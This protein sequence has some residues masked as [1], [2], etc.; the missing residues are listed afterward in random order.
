V[1]LLR[2]AQV[3]AADSDQHVLTLDEAL[4]LAR[5]N[6]PQL[7]AARAQTEV[8]TA[9]VAEAKA[10]L[11][12]Q[13]NGSCFYQRSRANSPSASMAH[14]HRHRDRHCN[15]NVNVVHACVERVLGSVLQR[16]ALLPASS[17]TTSGR[18]QESG[19]REGDTSVAGR[20]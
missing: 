14:S 12:P 18:R 20:K 11:L 2:A 16:E 19:M 17:S 4:R 15:V 8:S 7:H 3:R 10:P 13:V 5:A 9:R 6:H 1:L